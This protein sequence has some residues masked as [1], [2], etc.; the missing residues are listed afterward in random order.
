VVRDGE[1][2]TIEPDWGTTY[3][4]PH[5]VAAGGLRFVVVSDT[6]FGDA[7]TPIWWSADGRTWTRGT[8]LRSG[9]VTDV[10]ATH[11]GF[12]ATGIDRNGAAA[13]RSEDGGTWVQTIDVPTAGDVDALWGVEQ[14]DY[15]YFAWGHVGTMPRM[16][17]SSDG[18]TWTATDLRGMPGGGDTYVCDVADSTEGGLVATGGVRRGGAE[19]VVR[20]TS[21]DGST[22]GRART[23]D[24]NA[25][26]TCNNLVEAHWSAT[27][28]IGTVRVEPYGQEGRVYFSPAY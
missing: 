17:R 11:D 20:W 2:E 9:N 27:S 10:I 5:A 15:G 18:R 28:A 21:R 23:T 13:Y 7:T 12:L 4:S 22:W 8:G 1:W 25:L 3:M 16:F 6:S 24:D 14:T 26:H 19:D